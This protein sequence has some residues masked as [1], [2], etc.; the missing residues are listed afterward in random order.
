MEVSSRN[1]MVG[2]ESGRSQRV[3][4]LPEKGFKYLVS[5]PETGTQTVTCQRWVGYTLIRL[6][7]WA[8]PWLSLFKLWSH[9]QTLTPDLSGPLDLFVPLPNVVMLDESLLFHFLLLT[10]LF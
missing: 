9:L 6:F 2:E 7:G 1:L 8:Y 4:G 3:A 10:R 5:S